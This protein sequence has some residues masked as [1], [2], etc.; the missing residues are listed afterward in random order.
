MLIHAQVVIIIFTDSF[1]KDYFLIV[2]SPFHIYVGDYLHQTQYRYW[3][4]AF[5]WES[6]NWDHFKF[7]LCPPEDLQ[8]LLASRQHQIQDI[9]K[10][11]SKT[12]PE[13]PL[14]NLA[15]TI[16]F[17]LDSNHGVTLWIYLSSDFTSSLLTFHEDQVYLRERCV[18]C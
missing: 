10:G 15:R 12:W 6:F 16:C 3:Y 2:C 13:R 8:L 18:S 4:L 5:Y 9:S 7:P 14:A 1:L 11:S 17:Y